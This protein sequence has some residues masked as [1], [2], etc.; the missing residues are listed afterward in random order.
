VL[1][2]GFFI[3]FCHHSVT[4]FKEKLFGSDGVVPFS[5]VGLKSFKVVGVNA[6]P[7]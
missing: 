1:S 4:V 6:P 3:L 5:V 7:G 2:I